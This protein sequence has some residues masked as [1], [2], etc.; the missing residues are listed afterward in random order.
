MVEADTLMR[1]LAVTARAVSRDLTQ[2]IEPEGLFGAEWAILALLHRGG[3]VSQ[4]ALATALALEPPA[5][6]K[7]LA[8]LESRAWIRRSLGPTRREH[9]VALTPEA[10]LHFARWEDAV[11]IHH[12]R[13]LDGFSLT[14]IDTLYA[15]LSRLRANL[16]PAEESIATP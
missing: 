9:R 3:P 10:E 12:A 16:R 4:A 8:R 13:A 1:T 11:T 15:L 6:S 5:I 7:A 14:E 2:T